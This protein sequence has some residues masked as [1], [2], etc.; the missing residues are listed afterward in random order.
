MKGHGQLLR[1]YSRMILCPKARRLIVELV[2]DERCIMGFQIPLQNKSVVFSSWLDIVL[3]PPHEVC[4]RRR[5]IAATLL[6]MDVCCF[7][8]ESA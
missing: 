3:A 5:N 2:F 4:E 8:S 6:G 7:H 1:L